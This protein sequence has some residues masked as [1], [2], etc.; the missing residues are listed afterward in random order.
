MLYSI[1]PT[2]VLSASSWQL[3][4]H[5]FFWSFLNFWTILDIHHSSCASSVWY[6]LSI[7]FAKGFPTSPAT[8]F[9]MMGY[10][11]SRSAVLSSFITSSCQTLYHLAIIKSQCILHFFSENSAPVSSV[12]S[13]FLC[14]SFSA[15]RQRCI[16]NQSDRYALF[17]LWIPESLCPKPSSQD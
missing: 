2:W 10:Y 5:L 3:E 1:H 4:S 7:R 13:S 9:I 14:F 6:E 15:L 8:Y 17:L 12:W 16:Y 11:S